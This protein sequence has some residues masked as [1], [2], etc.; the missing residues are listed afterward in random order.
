MEKENN[1]RR[2]VG[3]RTVMSGWDKKNL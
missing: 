1:A 2:V 3:K